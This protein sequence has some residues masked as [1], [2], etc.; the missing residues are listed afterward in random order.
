MKE[1]DQMRNNS[2]KRNVKKKKRTKRNSSGFSFLKLFL[3]VLVL[4]AAG[5]A[6]YTS[7]A[8]EDDSKAKDTDTASAEVED[9]DDLSDNGTIYSGVF[10]D[11]VYVG[12]LTKTEAMKEYEAYIN[13]IDKLKLTFTTGVGSFSTTF[14]DIGLQVSA[15][16][17]VDQA[18]DYGRKGN[19]LCRYKEIKS[20]EKDNAILVPE[21]TFSQSKLKNII[22]EESADIVAEP[23]NASISRVDGEFVV[24]DGVVGTTVKVDETVQA[25]EDLLAEV[26]KQKDVRIPAVVEEKQPQ[27]TAEDFEKI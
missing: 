21:K 19:I 7:W 1:D 22:E 3:A 11:D 13:G 2:T 9:G 8:K 20:L 12:G 24:T 18:Y 16:D 17:A 15:E 27:Y 10:L 26:W 6:V 14:K 4:G 23:Q 25:V 5:T